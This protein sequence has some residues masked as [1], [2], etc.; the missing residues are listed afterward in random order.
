MPGGLFNC[1]YYLGM[2]MFWE[3]KW[4]PTP[5]P[6]QAFVPGLSVEL[7]GGCLGPPELP[8]LRAP[9]VD[10]G[11]LSG[12][13]FLRLQRKFPA[14]SGSGR[15]PSILPPSLKLRVWQS[16]A[17]FL[18]INLRVGLAVERSLLCRYCSPALREYSVLGI[19][20]CP[21]YGPAFSKPQLNFSRNSTGSHRHPKRQFC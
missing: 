13:L 7:F 2:G 4:G 14:S 9:A 10:V 6:C 8:S 12:W 3:L 1:C 15:C 16:L 17:Y 19:P 11:G 21:P 18:T 5:S 20:H